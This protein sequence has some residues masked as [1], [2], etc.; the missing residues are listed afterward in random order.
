[1]DPRKLCDLPPEQFREWLAQSSQADREAVA[2]VLSERLEPCERAVECLSPAE[3]LWLLIILH[4]LLAVNGFAVD[5]EAALRL[6]G[7]EIP[8]E[9]ERRELYAIFGVSA[10]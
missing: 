4:R 2:S 9:A 8:G 1:M 5:P 6:V 7:P 3:A 10:A